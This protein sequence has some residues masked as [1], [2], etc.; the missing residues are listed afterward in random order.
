MKK[1]FLIIMLLII[2]S[3]N[4]SQAQGIV[5]E[6]Q[7][8]RPEAFY[9]Y[10]NGNNI[11][12]SNQQILKL[13]QSI[14][15]QQSALCDLKNYQSI[16]NKTALSNKIKSSSTILNE[17]DYLG[18][19][20]ITTALKNDII[21]ELNLEKIP[22]EIK[23]GVTVRRTNIR[24]LPSAQGLYESL[25]S[26]KFD[27]LQETVVDPGT[28]V[29]ILHTSKNNQ[30]YYIQTADYSGWVATKNVAVATKSDW[31]KYLEPQD[32]MV[33]TA[34]KKI[35][36][37][38]GE[39]LTYQMGA[40]IPLLKEDGSNKILMPYNKD[41]LN[42]YYLKLNNNDGLSEGYLPYTTNNI[43]KQS[44]KMLGDVYGWGGLENSVDCSSFVQ[45]IYKTFGINLPRNADQQELSLQR[46][47]YNAVTDSLKNADIN[48]LTKGSLLFMDGHVMLYLGSIKNEPYIIH[49]L[50][51]YS[52][53][54]GDG[55]MKKIPILKVVVSDLQL[56]RYSGKTF[57]T[58]LTSGAEIK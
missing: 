15:Q 23:Y 7:L 22:T 29:V 1:I 31:L 38:N 2:S 16:I 6:T 26:T 21:A 56:Q 44:F 32:F 17:Y 47:Y 25:K 30:F 19:G 45:N 4:I 3:N 8:L 50:G 58:A 55:T 39:V 14:S 43:I 5:Q 12:L 53:R 34:N 48:K 10:Q 24:T 49:A 18:S 46:H 42:N 57:L 52:I 20:L 9:D 33:V 13:N 36:N 40:K 11:I 41:G 27:Y 35:I 37:F 51:S 28:A 54:Q